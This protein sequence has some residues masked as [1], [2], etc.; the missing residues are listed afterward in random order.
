M[1]CSTLIQAQNS[2]LTDSIPPK[3]E[4]ADVATEEVDGLFAFAEYLG[5]KLYDEV[6]DQF[7]EAKPEEKAEIKRVRI[8]LGPIKIERVEKR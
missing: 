3:K 8:K 5:K 2:A 4:V 1:L 7:D 6:S